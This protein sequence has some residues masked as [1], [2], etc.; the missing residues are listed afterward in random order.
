MD[1]CQPQ[2]SEKAN[3]AAPHRPGIKQYLASQDIDTDGSHKNKTQIA[4]SA[5]YLQGF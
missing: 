3:S 5:I 2:L 1:V 4:I